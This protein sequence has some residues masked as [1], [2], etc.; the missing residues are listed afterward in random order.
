MLNPVNGLNLVRLAMVALVILS[1]SFTVGHFGAAPRVLDITPG[2]WA[3]AGLFTVSGFLVSS[4]RLRRT[5]AVYFWHRLLRIWPAFLLCL[6][7]ITVVFAPMVYVMQHGS[8]DGY[9]TAEEG[10]LRFLTMNA[11]LEIRQ[12]EVSGTPATNIT[13]W[14]GNLWTIWYTVASYAVLGVILGIR[15]ARVR[16]YVTVGAFVVVVV[17]YANLDFVMPYL[18]NA[19]IGD[20]LMRFLPWFIGGS[21]VYQLKDRLRLT[22]PFALTALA[23]TFALAWVSPDWGLQAAAPLIGYALLYVG[24]VL[25]APGALRVNDF[26]MGFFMYSFAVQVVLAK[27][28]IPELVGSPWLFFVVSMIATAPFAVL[29]WF[30]AERPVRDR[31]RRG[32]R[33]VSVDG[34]EVRSR[35]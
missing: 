35:V 28:G 2:G 26:A 29:S 15:D 21:L 34:S 20:G 27:L 17:A 19:R 24:N 32:E 18:Q 13:G 33:V 23:G 10:P 30:V 1:H 5:Y 14:I 8:V 16:L 12:F 11:L 31:L 25:P 3:L 9:L 6:L 7:V 22:L 4:G